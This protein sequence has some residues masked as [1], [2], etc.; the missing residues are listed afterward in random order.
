MIGQS[1]RSFLQTVAAAAGVAVLKDAPAQTA[2]VEAPAPGIIDT[3]VSLGQWPF[4]RHELNDTPALVAKLRANGITEAWASSFDAL[5]HKD[6][7]SV[8][9]RIAEECRNHGQGLLT[10]VGAINPKLP[11]W[12]ED[13]RRCA[14]VHQ[15]RAIRLYPNYHGYQLGDAVF[16]RL[17]QR[18]EERGLLVQIAVVMEEERTIHP[19]VSVP[20]T[21]AAPLAA[22]LEK[23]PKIRVQ[24]LNAFR[25]LR[26][27]PLLSLASRGVGFEIAMLEG[28]AGIARLLEKFPSQRL[29]FGSHAPFFYTESARL[30]LQESALDPEQMKALCFENARRFLPSK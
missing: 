10:P 14:E 13:L 26:G 25:T 6:I 21:D 18:A 29:C 27:A 9:T 7:S 24:L 23:F 8:N 5:L 20:A 15:M 28:V 3:N 1:R 22:V 12:E 19:L 17:G 11:G 16:E 30:K 4:R 2:K